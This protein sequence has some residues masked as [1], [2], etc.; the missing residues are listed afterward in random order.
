MNTHKQYITIQE[1]SKITGK[2]KDTI[3]RLVKSHLG[4]EYITKG[5]RSQ[6]L[7][8]KDWLQSYYEIN[9]PL[10]ADKSRDNL[11]DDIQ[12]T[13]NNSNILERTIEALTSQLEAKDKQIERLQNTIDKLT[14]DYSQLFNQSQVLQKMLLPEKASTAEPEQPKKKKRRLFK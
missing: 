6:Y 5:K 14:G 8:N 12:A 2:H 7:L 10:Q 1:A 3:R 13:P 9:E 4:S 11:K